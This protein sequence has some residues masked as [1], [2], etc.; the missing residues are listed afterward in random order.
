MVERV[1][2]AVAVDWQGNAWLIKASRCIPV[3]S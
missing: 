2:L 3:T 1:V